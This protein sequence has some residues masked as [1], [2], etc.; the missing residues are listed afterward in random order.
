MEMKALSLQTEAE[1]EMEVLLK[2][3]LCKYFIK[4]NKMPKQNIL[5]YFKAIFIVME[6]T[7]VIMRS[8]NLGMMT[9]M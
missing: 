6:R 3:Q 5:I 2:H 7:L 9:V 1:M 8:V 4:R